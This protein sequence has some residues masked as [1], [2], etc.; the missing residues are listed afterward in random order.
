MVVTKRLVAHVP[1]DPEDE[2]GVHY[3]PK[4]G[5]PVGVPAPCARLV[6]GY[7]C[8]CGSGFASIEGHEQTSRARVEAAPEGEWRGFVD[9]S[10]GYLE[11]GVRWPVE[12]DRR[13]LQEQVEALPIGTVVERY[14]T[15][16]ARRFTDPMPV[17]PAWALDDSPF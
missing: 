14:G 7:W 16:I 9:S 12:S 13:D 15:G 4:D 8:S 5:D 1:P 17:A 10:G 11:P 6:A 2:L 3:G